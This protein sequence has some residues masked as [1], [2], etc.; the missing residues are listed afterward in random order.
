MTMTETTAADFEV[1]YPTLAVNRDG[2]VQV[3]KYGET[4]NP[5]GTCVCC[6]STLDPDKI[7]IDIGLFIEFHGTVYF[8]NYCFKDV[9][10][11][12]RYIPVEGKH[13]VELYTKH[14]KAVNRIKELEAE[15]A[16]SRE[17]A[18]NDLLINLSTL[19]GASKPVV[20]SASPVEKSSESVP[21]IDEILG[22]RE[23]VSTTKPGKSG[24]SD[25]PLAEQGSPD[26]FGLTELED[27]DFP[28][29]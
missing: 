9:T 16:N 20:S 3:I 19:L 4:Y 25:R 21:T 6:G 8:C 18:Y 2:K 1:T 7:F 29:L 27:L 14:A 5:P 17:Q 22:A 24:S 23:T 26:L 12:M 11:A 15:V 10:E 13:Y 28:N